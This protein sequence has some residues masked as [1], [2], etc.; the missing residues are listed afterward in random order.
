MASL[1]WPPRAALQ[2]LALQRLVRQRMVVSVRSSRQHAHSP[3]AVA[4]SRVRAPLGSALASGLA[5]HAGL[6]AIAPMLPVE[7][8]A[9]PAFIIS[10]TLL[11]G[12]GLTVLLWL[13]WRNGGPSRFGAANQVTLLRAGMVMLLL[14]IVLQTPQAEPSWKIVLLASLATALDG[15]DGW[16][17]RRLGLVSAFGAR[18]DMEVDALLIVALSLLAWR[19]DQA[20]PWVLVCGAIRYVFVL[21]A[22]PWPWLARPLPYSRRRQA[23]CV[24]QVIALIV[25]LLPVLAPPVSGLFALAGLLALSLSFAID[26]RWLARRSHAPSEVTTR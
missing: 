9:A 7:T 15:C 2:R 12:L 24:V 21:A 1:L 13:L 14:T 18:F 6:L 17:A 3:S 19:L 22:R 20:G 26:V 25:C 5:V 8:Q 4:T 16:L 23:L 11:S 10:F